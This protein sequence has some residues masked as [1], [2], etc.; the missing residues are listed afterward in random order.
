MS[1]KTIAIVDF[2]SQFTQLIA[3]RVREFNVYSEIISPASLELQDLY[4]GIILSGGPNSVD[5]NNLYEKIKNYAYKLFEINEKFSTPILGI[6]FGKQLICKHFGANILRNHKPEF[7]NAIINITDKS[8]LTYQQ[9]NLKLEPGVNINVWMSH[10]DSAESLPE[11]FR[12]IASTS[13]CEFAIIE[14]PEKDIYGL[15]FHPEVVHSEN[16]AQLLNNFLNICNCTRSWSTNSFLVQQYDK[17]KNTVANKKVIAAVSGGVDSTVAAALT[18]EAIKDQLT[19]IFIDT[20]L[21]RKNEM[22]QVQ[23]TFSE[24]FHIKV[25]F[26][27]KSKLFLSKLKGIIDP[28]QKRKIIGNTFIE[29]FE[30]ES[31]KITDAE[32][33]LQGTLYPDVIESGLG[34][35][36]SIKSH[37]NVGGLPEKLKLKL[38]EPLRYLFKDE[39]R[40][41]GLELGI[42]SQLINRHPFPGPG[43]A[44][45]IIGEITQEKINLLQEADDIYISELRKQGFYN[46]IWQAFVVLLPV[47]TVGVM[48]DSRTYEHACVLRAITSEDGMTADVFPFKN[49]E[50]NFWEF[51]QHVSNRIVNEVKGINRV[52]YDITSKPP[53]TIEWE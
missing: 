2:G 50:A 25:Q 53:G 19:C 8:K 18:H 41:L 22:A 21:L 10:S 5:D 44:I 3:R 52:T 51:L 20:G 49:K 15:Q 13:R 36:A 42:S 46:Q 35:S 11:S 34:M 23:K 14:N 4:A 17:I 1:E 27:D 29:V 48:G 12:K 30:E 7:G 26:C 24:Q 39:V 38:L 9:N 32:F 43:L 28:E 37:H 47:K 6:C 33:L 45:R 16:G 31:N 40:K